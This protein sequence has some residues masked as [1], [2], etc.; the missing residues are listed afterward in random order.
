L[1]LLPKKKWNLRLGLI[2]L[3]H[4][5]RG[6]TALRDEKFV[7]QLARQFGVSFVG[8]KESVK[9]Y[10]KVHRLS[11]EEAARTLRYRFFG[12]AAREHKCRSLAL[13]HTLNDQAETVLM[14]MIQG[15]GSKGLLGI[16]ETMKLGSLKV[17][18]P[19]LFCR[20]TEILFF[21]EKNRFK[22]CTDETNKK[23]VYLRNRL[24]L[25]LL[26]ALEKDYN[27]RVQEALARIPAIIQEETDGL[28]ELVDHYAGKVLRSKTKDRITLDTVSFRELPAALQFRILNR[29]LANID[30]RSGINYDNWKN[31]KQEL[32]RNSF[33]YSLKKN[34]DI[35]ISSSR[36]SIYKRK[37][38]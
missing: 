33:R 20:K 9:T 5:M 38:R 26:P 30:A 2:H 7:K 16:R 25:E 32:L 14:R 35:T 19:L 15:T 31:L 22:Y 17:I 21:L 6:K 18:R 10:A 28:E 4:G 37:T 29:L 23:T 24:R 36:I 27:P 8:S 34:I 11:P 12:E 1:R 13:A 3:N